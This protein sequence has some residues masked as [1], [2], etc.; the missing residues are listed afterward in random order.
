MVDEACADALLAAARR[1]CSCIRASE[2]GVSWTC[3]GSEARAVCYRLQGCVEE[4]RG[5]LRLPARPGGPMQGA[6]REEG[7]LS[8]CYRMV[9]AA[10]SRATG[11]GSPDR[12]ESLVGRRP[13]ENPYALFWLCAETG[14]PVEA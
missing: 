2:R 12:V 8:E 5:L 1:L 10:A 7:C 4:C 3:P 11:R 9:F 6:L 14:V 13:W